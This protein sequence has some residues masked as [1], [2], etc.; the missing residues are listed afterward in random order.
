MR[1]S[2][3]LVGTS[4][5]VPLRPTLPMAWNCRE[6]RPPMELMKMVADRA[7]ATITHTGYTSPVVAKG[8][9]TPLHK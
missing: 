2:R 5:G 9:P 1:V 3:V 6:G 7:I 4:Q 8:M